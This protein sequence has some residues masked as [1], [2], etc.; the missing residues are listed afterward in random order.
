MSAPS[1]KEMAEAMAAVKDAM[2]E[3]N[4]AVNEASEKIRAAYALA[5]RKI[6]EETRKG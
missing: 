6:N 3:M 2:N 5:A 4:R 1:H